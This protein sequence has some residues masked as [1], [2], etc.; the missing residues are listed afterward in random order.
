MAFNFREP[1]AFG[2]G[3]TVLKGPTIRCVTQ[4][5]WNIVEQHGKRSY[6][7]VVKS[8]RLFDQDTNR[9][10]FRETQTLTRM[11]AVDEVDFLF[12]RRAGELDQLPPLFARIRQ[13]PK[14][15]MIGIVLG[16]VEI[17]VHA[18]RPAEFK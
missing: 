13:S 12:S 17:S 9:F 3:E 18:A 5:R 8:L 16:R 15:A 6:A 2:P 10:V 14:L 11:N 7:A 4:T 1:G